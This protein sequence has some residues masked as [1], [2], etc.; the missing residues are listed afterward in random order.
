MTFNC[1]KSII[2][3]TCGISYE[4]IVVDNASSDGSRDFFKDLTSIKYIYLDHNLGFGKANNIGAEY[5]RGKYLF[6]LNSDT[7]LRNNAVQILSDFIESD[8][9]CGAVGGNLYNINGKPTI[10][11]ERIFPGIAHTFNLFTHN[12]INQF[13]YGKNTIFNNSKKPL[14]VAYI[15]GADFMIPKV[16]FDKL[17]GFSPDFFMYYEETDLCFRLQK[18]GYSVKSVPAAEIFHLEGGSQLKDSI[19][20]WKIST[21]A[22]SRRVFMK[23]NYSSL[24][25]IIDR[26]FLHSFLLFRATIKPND[27]QSLI[28]LKEFR[29]T[30]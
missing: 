25:Q 17:N 5:A 22:Y 19:N 8:P 9:P 4:I 23:R 11:F 26:F 21:S 2:K 3:C 20:I 14:K 16:L 1:I 12:L 29:K 18:L 30:S 13:R 24:Y 15:S 28:E 6:F 7:L 10:S 27:P